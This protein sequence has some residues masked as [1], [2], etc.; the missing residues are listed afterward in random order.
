[1]KI[2]AYMFLAVLVITL[3]AVIVILAKGLIKL[4][5]LI[6]LTLWVTSV[7]YRINK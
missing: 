4:A 1:M 3:F 6:V 5:C 7:L 2:I